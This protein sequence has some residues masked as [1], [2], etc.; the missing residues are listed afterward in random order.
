VQRVTDTLSEITAAATEQ[1]RGIGQINSA[2]AALD[3]MTQQNSALVEQSAAAADTMNGHAVQLAAAV[4]T[5]KAT[6]N[7]PS[8][9]MQ[10]SD[11]SSSFIESSQSGLFPSLQVLNVRVLG[12][13]LRPYGRTCASSSC[14]PR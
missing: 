13:T 10:A 7:K 4:S 1:S 3:Q 11:R 9:H 12:P 5:F 2:I 14:R 8:Q 6:L